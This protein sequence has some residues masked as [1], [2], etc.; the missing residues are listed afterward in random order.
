M[1]AILITGTNRGIGLE[2]T[3]QYLNEGWRVF[4]CSRHAD[5]SKE[6]NALK[7]QH[8]TLLTLA[9]LDVRDEKQIE[10]LANEWRSESFDI[11][12]NNAGI[13]GPEHIELGALNAKDWEAVFLVNSISPLL[14]TQ[15][16][17][18]QVAKSEKKIIATMSSLMGS[19]TDNTS[20]RYYYY[21]SSKAAANAAMKSLAIDLRNRKITGIVFHPGWV[22]TDMGG[23]DAPLSVSESVTGIRKVLGQLTLADS[24][25]FLNYRGD[26]LSW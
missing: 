25:K 7:K 10:S 19:I 20:G 16:F 13:Y 17:L 5:E 14:V 18:E 4:A 1:A 15:A 3:K 11:L 8:P 26:E 6:L 21:R 9:S 24:G 2:L 22:Q 23:P 12:F